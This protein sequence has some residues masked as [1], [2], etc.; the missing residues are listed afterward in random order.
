M[1][2]FEDVGVG[3]VDVLLEVFIL[4]GG[5]KLGLFFILGVGG[6]CCTFTL[7]GEARVLR[8]HPTFRTGNVLLYV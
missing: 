3:E 4:L 6:L 2:G 5:T 8:I 7:E 1:S